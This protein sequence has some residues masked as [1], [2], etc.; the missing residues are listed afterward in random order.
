MWA[1]MRFDLNAGELDYYGTLC[2]K[3]MIVHR[4]N[5]RNSRAFD[6]IANDGCATALAVH[7]LARLLVRILR[8]PAAVGCTVAAIM[9]RLGGI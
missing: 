9:R 6:G 2:R 8:K 4:L 1:R 3:V 7:M 5:R